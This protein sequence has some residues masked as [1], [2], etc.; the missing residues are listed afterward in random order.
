VRP[1]S[2]AR[3]VK[4]LQKSEGQCAL[5]TAERES[6]AGREVDSL[7]IGGEQLDHR[8]MRPAFWNREALAVFFKQFHGPL[9]A[10]LADEI[11][12]TNRSIGE[13]AIEARRRGREDQ[14]G[15]EEQGRDF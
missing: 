5:A 10:A 6:G 7:G 3:T 4:S 13:E 15:G 12:F 14:N 2:T 1:F 11:G 9:V 8:N